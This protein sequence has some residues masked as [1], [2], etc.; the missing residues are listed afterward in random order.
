M[1]LYTCPKCKQQ[2]TAEHFLKRSSLIGLRAKLCLKCRDKFLNQMK[3][4]PRTPFDYGL[5][6]KYG[7][8]EA[9]FNKMEQDQNG[10][11]AICFKV[12]ERGRLVVDHDHNTGKVRGLLCN[13]CNSGMGKL[14]DSIENLESAVLYLKRTT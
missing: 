5:K 12:P 6:H 2:Y 10:K 7:I 3:N 11:C 13:T 1:E 9:D 8:R 14:G 4:G